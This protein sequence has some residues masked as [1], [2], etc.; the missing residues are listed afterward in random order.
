VAEKG[1]NGGGRA[2]AIGA[3]FIAWEL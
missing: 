3:H 2:G 1:S